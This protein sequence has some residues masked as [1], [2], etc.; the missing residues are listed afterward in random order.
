MHL[1]RNKRIKSD[2]SVYNLPNK[3]TFQAEA[4][5]LIKPGEWFSPQ[6]TKIGVG[7]QWSSTWKTSQ[8]S[9]TNDS[10]VI[11]RSWTSSV[12]WWF[13][14]P[15]TLGAGNFLSNP[16]MLP[17]WRSWIPHGTICRK[18]VRS[19]VTFSARPWYVTHWDARIPIA[20]NFWSS[21]RNSS[22]RLV[23]HASPQNKMETS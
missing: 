12:C 19:A 6:E 21:E 8:N 22:I 16:F 18:G 13:S 11:S 3:L 15:Q 7:L 10:W 20:P 2:H 5:P 23:F 4:F 9:L 1:K 14:V 17:T